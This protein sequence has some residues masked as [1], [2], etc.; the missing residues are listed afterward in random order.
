MDDKPVGVE[1]DK[2]LVD[3]G[4]VHLHLEQ[5]PRRQ[6]C[7]PEREIRQRVPTPWPWASADQAVSM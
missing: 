6:V 7:R 3:L 4:P 5:E 1:G 2:H